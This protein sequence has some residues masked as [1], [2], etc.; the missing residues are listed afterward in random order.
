[1]PVDVSQDVNT[2]LIVQIARVDSFSGFINVPVGWRSRKKRTVLQVY[3]Q[4]AYKSLKLP[5]GKCMGFYALS[6]A[7]VHDP[8]MVAHHLF[9]IGWTQGA[10]FN[11]V[12]IE[13]QFVVRYGFDAACRETGR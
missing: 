10:L 6:V 4:S 8:N 13:R 5:K 12:M 9:V 2:Q 3:L 1:M 7:S 11:V